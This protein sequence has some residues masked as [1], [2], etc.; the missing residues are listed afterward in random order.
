MKDIMN[1]DPYDEISETKKLIENIWKT[2]DEKSLKLQ[3]EELTK[4]VIIK[5]DHITMKK[6]DDIRNIQKNVEIYKQRL[7]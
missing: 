1:G 7:T 5:G 3:L 4:H 6:G 2:K